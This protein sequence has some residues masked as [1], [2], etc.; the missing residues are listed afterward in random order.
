LLKRRGAGEVAPTDG[1]LEYGYRE[2]SFGLVDK[3][4]SGSSEERSE[5]EGQ[6]ER[7]Q[8]GLLINIVERVEG[9]YRSLLS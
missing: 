3:G 6:E 5:E 7:A 1:V 2:P 4:G 8:W 9:A